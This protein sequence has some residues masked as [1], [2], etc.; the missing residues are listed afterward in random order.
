MDQ[1]RN[2]IYGSFFGLSLGDSLAA[3]YEFYVPTS[4]W[5][6]K[7]IPNFKNKHGTISHGTITDDT[8]MTICLL[9]SLV[10][11]NGIYNVKDVTEFYIKWARS[12]SKIGKNTKYLLKVKDYDEY[13]LKSN[14]LFNNNNNNNPE[15]I[16]KSNG[17]LMRCLPLFL[18]KE[19]DIIKD[20][21]ITNPNPINIEAEIIYLSLLR[22]CFM[23]PQNIGKQ[24]VYNYLYH[25][26][27][28][29]EEVKNYIIYAVNKV[30]I[31]MVTNKG[32]VLIALYSAIYCLLHFNSYIEGIDW[33]I[34]G[35]DGT[36]TDTN[37][38]IAGSLMGIFYGYDNLNQQE[39]LNTLFNIKTSRPKYLQISETPQLL[40]EWIKILVNV[41]IPF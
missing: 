13:I 23:N 6:G 16:S 40:E 3:P 36:D 8:E 1:F 11:N 26:Q 5:N 17:S 10:K 24:E 38:C 9:R 15:N 20:C 33:L 14:T 31:D 7:I 12:S 2:K 22:I 19:E 35:R 4:F 18:S 28:K 25:Y 34:K 29:N 21:S 32:Y 27:Y 39:N 37:C 41:R 30:N